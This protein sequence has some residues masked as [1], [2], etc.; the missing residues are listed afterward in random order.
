MSTSIASNAPTSNYDATSDTHN[1][2]LGAAVLVLAVISIVVSVLQLLSS[3]RCLHHPTENVESP[4]Q[5]HD[6][7][8]GVVQV[9]TDRCSLQSSRSQSTVRPTPSTSVNVA[10]RRTSLETRL[11]GNL[12]TLSPSTFAT[13]SHDTVTHVNESI[14]TRGVVLPEHS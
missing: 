5:I 12:S 4:R 9:A 11:N 14:N 13:S 8:M 3:C 1:M 7:E 10:Q 2:I 6:L